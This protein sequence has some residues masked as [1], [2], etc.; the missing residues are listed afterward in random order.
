MTSAGSMK[1]GELLIFTAN[2]VD[3]A[4]GLPAIGLTD[5]LSCQGRYDPNGDLVTTFIIAETDTP[6]TYV[7]QSGPSSS[8][9]TGR[10]LVDIKYD[11]PGISPIHT[12]TFS[13]SIEKGVT[14]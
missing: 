12:E 10:L 11:I 3:T 14:E 9:L 13:V 6:G 1:K 8:W 5:R 2:L 7:F 4:T